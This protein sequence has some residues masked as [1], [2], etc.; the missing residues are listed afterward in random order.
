MIQL[1]LNQPAPVRNYCALGLAEIAA[2]DAI[3][4]QAAAG[5]TPEIIH[6]VW[7][8]RALDQAP[9]YP[10]TVGIIRAPRAIGGCSVC[11]NRSTDQRARASANGCAG[12][13]STRV[14]VMSVMTVMSAD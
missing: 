7:R 12:D 11:I 6:L 8:I 5:N 4:H 3:V 13:R 14:P 10:P 2:S 1:L 9:A